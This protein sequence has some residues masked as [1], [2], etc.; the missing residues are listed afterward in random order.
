MTARQ[1]RFMGVTMAATVALMA[2][3]TGQSSDPRT[4]QVE[5]AIA[6]HRGNTALR[7][8]LQNAPAVDA[9][10]RA[11]TAIEASR[12]PSTP[13]KFNC[14]GIGASW[15]EVAPKACCELF[16]RDKRGNVD[17]AWIA[18][19]QCGWRNQ[20]EVRRP[21]YLKA[22]EACLASAGLGAT[23]APTPT[24]TR[25]AAGD[26]TDPWHGMLTPDQVRALVRGRDAFAVFGGAGWQVYDSAGRVRPM[27]AVLADRVRR[28][29]VLLSDRA[30]LIA[31]LAGMNLKLGPEEAAR[32][33]AEGGPAVDRQFVWFGENLVRFYLAGASLFTSIGPGV[34]SAGDPGTCRLQ[35]GIRRVS[36]EH[37]SIRGTINGGCDFIRLTPRDDGLWRSTPRLVLAAWPSA[38]GSVGG[39]DLYL[40][41]PG[42]TVHALNGPA[43]V[44]SDLAPNG[45]VAVLVL[46]GQVEVRSSQPARAVLVSAGNAA[47]VWPGAG[48]SRPAAVSADRLGAAMTPRIRGGVTLRPGEEW[49]GELAIE[50]G[51]LPIEARLPW[52]RTAGSNYA[53][54]ITINGQPLTAA[55]ANKMSP[56]RYADGRNFPYLEPGRNRWMLFYSPDFTANN[57]A[58]GG[59][60]EVQTDRGQAYRY[61]WD[62]GTLLRGAP[63]AQ[64]RFRN[65]ADAK[66]GPTIELRLLAAASVGTRTAVPPPSGGDLAD[67]R[68]G[69]VQARSGRRLVLTAVPDPVAVG[70]DELLWVF[71][72]AED[73]RGR[74]LPWGKSDQATVTSSHPTLLRAYGSDGHLARVRATGLPPYATFVAPGEGTVTLTASATGFAPATLAVRTARYAPSGAASLRVFAA[75]A[76]VLA[77]ERPLVVVRYATLAG[78]PAL[79]G[80]RMD[81]AVEATGPDGVVTRATTLF[82][83]DTYTS[84]QASL[85]MASVAGAT[86]LRATAPGFTSQPVR[87]EVVDPDA[88]GE[89]A[90]PPVSAPVP[91]T[92]GAP[93]RSR[94][95]GVARNDSFGEPAVTGRLSNIV[96]A[97]DVRQGAAVGITDQFTPDV[98]PIHVWFRVSGFAPGTTLLSR[99]SYLGGP[100]PLVIG[101]A[102]TTVTAGND[103]GTFS[104]ELAP[105]KR[106]PAGDYKAEILVGDSPVGMAM[107]SVVTR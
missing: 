85:N 88:G 74:L 101:T 28:G 12:N 43:R 72:Q 103:Y 78:A 22:A 20:V 51:Q 105:G 45:A 33:L 95:A 48:V 60:Y 3:A 90:A 18:L 23:A 29:A 104:Y 31:A 69:P 1:Q 4:R 75:P 86:T 50:Q 36:S 100:Q 11:V 77:G 87:V 80:R 21:A 92:L 96:T 40:D 41:L 35:Q 91:L 30:W 7:Q 106:W 79:H 97:R 9:Y 58:A 25:P 66:P 63:S 73:E 53:L 27:P 44:V 98:N 52:E 89:P 38:Q 8:C 6:D 56:M 65:V 64:V 61:V 16:E 42:A 84:T 93:A 32:L 15:Q 37:G 107:F 17:A 26:Q 55:V 71:V 46:S 54:E 81:V 94:T 67:R 24:A 76:R 62:L 34:T 2:A 82:Y 10:N 13:A 14:S 39:D 59:V 49:M 102:E 99:W 83:G 68:D 5:Q 57:G 19:Q 70:T 47:V